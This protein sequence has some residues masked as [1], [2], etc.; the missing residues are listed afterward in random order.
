[1]GASTAKPAAKNSPKK[2]RAGSPNRP[3]AKRTARPVKRATPKKDA[4][5]PAR[6]REGKPARAPATKGRGPKAAAGPS[7]RPV[8]RIR[9]PFG[10]HGAVL[11]DLLID[12]MDLLLAQGAV[13]LG[14]NPR[15]LVVERLARHGRDT[16]AQISG[17]QT[18]EQAEQL[19]GQVL[20]IRAELLPALPEGVFYHY[21]ILNLQVVTDDG[22]HLGTVAE[23]LQT[24]ANDVYVVRGESG[25]I[26][27]PAIESVVRKVALDEGTL[28]V[29]LID[30]LLPEG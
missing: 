17:F 16:I 6:P 20:W 3:A 30:G 21:Q 14:E 9:R 26:L 7:R 12:N 2:T 8:A 29:H 10:I 11:L 18:R 19:R 25:E 15:P 5:L 4:G 13:T 22:R 24:G 1:M 27:L 28:T 23:I